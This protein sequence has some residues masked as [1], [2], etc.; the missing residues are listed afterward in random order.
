MADREETAEGRT[1]QQWLN[2]GWVVCGIDA[3]DAA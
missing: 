3:M 2:A 1:K